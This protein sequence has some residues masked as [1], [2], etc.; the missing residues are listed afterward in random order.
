MHWS[1]GPLAVFLGGS[2]VGVAADA[3]SEAMQ[4][5]GWVDGL[6][7]TA[8]A[9]GYV[10]SLTMDGALTGWVCNLA[11]PSQPLTL[12]FAVGGRSIGSTTASGLFFNDQD[13]P[14]IPP[15]APSVLHLR[16]IFYV[17]DAILTGGKEV[18]SMTAVNPTTNQ[19][20]RFAPGAAAAAGTLKVALRPRLSS[21]TPT[22]GTGCL[23]HARCRSSGDAL[24]FGPPWFEPV[25]LSDVLL[26]SQIWFLCNTVAR[27]CC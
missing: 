2:I 8:R 22:V 15:P 11:D 27:A 16:F 20:A 23:G 3:D 19:S 4:V 9:S 14:A 13:P 7:T 5:T 26:G 6:P 21:Y 17:P 1:I 12:H 18:L 25:P 24:S 10:I